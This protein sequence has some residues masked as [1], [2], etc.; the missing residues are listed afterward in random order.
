MKNFTLEQLGDLIF[1]E[2]MQ[3]TEMFF[4]T[5]NTQV[6]D[7]QLWAALHIGMMVGLMQGGYS[8]ELVQ[9]AVNIAMQKLEAHYGPQL[10]GEIPK[11]KD[12]PV[13]P[14]ETG[15]PSPYPFI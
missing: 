14:P 10:R 5:F 12:P 7:R 15:I 3:Y 9:G 4:F 11:R 13:E 8:R 6:M 1:N 2:T